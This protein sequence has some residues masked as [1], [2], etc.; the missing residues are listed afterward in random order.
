MARLS[1]C[2][3]VAALMWSLF[4]NVRAR[5]A[6]IEVKSKTFRAGDDIIYRVA[7]GSRRATGRAD[8]V[9]ARMEFV[10]VHR[11]NANRWYEQHRPMRF[12]VCSCAHAHADALTRTST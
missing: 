11:D 2:L 8:E 6:L 5:Y 9:V 12:I 3:F 7:S 1:V 4:D 10:I